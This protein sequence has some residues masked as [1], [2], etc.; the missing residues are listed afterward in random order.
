MA[1]AA[2]TERRKNGQK[3]VFLLLKKIT[4]PKIFFL[5]ISSSYAKILG[6]QIS[7]HGRFPI[8]GL[9][10]KTEREKKERGPNDGNNN[11]QVM[12]GV[13]NLLNLKCNI[14]RL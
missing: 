4:P 9:K 12:H 3:S 2:E 6:K 13:R 5:H 14:Y 10:Q 11:G 7:A 1:Q 8:V